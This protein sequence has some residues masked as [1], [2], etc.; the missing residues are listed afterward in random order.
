MTDV[1]Y[2]FQN[3]NN[4]KVTKATCKHCL[5]A[6][7][8]RIIAVERT[9]KVTGNKEMANRVSCTRCLKSCRYNKKYKVIQH[10]I[11]KVTHFTREE[12]LTRKWYRIK[13]WFTGDHVYGP[14]GRK[15]TK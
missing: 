2:K 14:F 11:I 1:K 5:E 13:R 10:P 15:R 12:L 9:N 7:T 6:A 4:E 8:F 3:K